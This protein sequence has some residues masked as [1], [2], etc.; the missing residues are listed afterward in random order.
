MRSIW[1]CALGGIFGLG[2]IT[3]AAA[4]AHA[5]SDVAELYLYTLVITALPDA[6]LGT[7]G[8]VVA[9]R[10]ELPG[11]GLSIAETAVAVP[12]TVFYSTFYAAYQAKEDDQGSIPMFLLMPTVATSILSTHG[13]WSTATTQV[14]PGVLAGASIA[15]GVDAALSTGAIASTLSGQLSGRDIGVATLALTAPQIAVGGYLVATT[16]ASDRAGWIGLT[17]WSGA[18][19]LHGLASTIRGHRANVILPRSSP[20]AWR[21][22]ND[23]PRLVVP[24]SIR[25][26]PTVVTDGVASAPGLGVSG[27]LF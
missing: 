3:T 8:V 27:V 26:G 17:A 4:P 1:R 9:A 2:L 10:G 23:G 12:Q 22:P 5:F 20:M 11:R 6:A 19:F 14:R 25:V 21:A 15:V 24:G 16:P 13:I 18:L 7:Y